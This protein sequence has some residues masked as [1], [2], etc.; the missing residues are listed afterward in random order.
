MIAKQ[1]TD[2]M[3]AAETL[4][5]LNADYMIRKQCEARADYY[6]LHN[7]INK[8]LYTLTAE[9]KNLTSENQNLTSENQSL[10]SEIKNLTQDNQKKDL[11]IRQ[12]KAQLNKEQPTV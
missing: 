3:E 10:N 8:K 9:V 12:L 5:T 4:Y 2:L 1:N 7:S 6:R 11:L